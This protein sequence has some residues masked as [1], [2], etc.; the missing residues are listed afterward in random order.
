[1]TA[2]EMFKLAS[3]IIKNNKE[4]IEVTSKKHAYIP[5]LD[6]TLTNTNPVLFNMDECLGL[7]TGTTNR[8]GCCLVSYCKF[9]DRRIVSVVFG[10]ETSQERGEKSELLMRYA[11]QIVKTEK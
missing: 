1:M 8:A 9:N 11:R 4:A 5:S 7:K 3:F 10:A 2:L 6:I